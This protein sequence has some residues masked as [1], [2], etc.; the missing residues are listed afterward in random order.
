MIPN[1][2]RGTGSERFLD[3]AEQFPIEV[4][5]FASNMASIPAA[6]AKSGLLSQF[7]AGQITTGQTE[8]PDNSPAAKQVCVVV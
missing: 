6:A 8:T 1:D 4:I 5:T 3:K 2:F 7:T